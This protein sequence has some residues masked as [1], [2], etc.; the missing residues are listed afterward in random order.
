CF[1]CQLSAQ[2]P[3]LT[4]YL[5]DIKYDDDIPTPESYLGYQIG[6]W[7]LSHDQQLAYLRLLADRSPRVTLTEYA[8]TFERRPLIYLTITSEKNQ[9]RLPELQEAHLA[10][11]DPSKEAPD[12]TDIPA[13]VYQGFAIHGNEPS[14]GNAA[15]LVAY[16]LAAAKGREVERLLDEVIILLDPCL[17]PDG[18]HRFSTWANMHKNQRLTGDPVEREYNEVWPRGRTNHYWFDLNRDWLLVQMPESQG[19]I[20]AFQSWKPNVLTDHHEMGANAT[21]FF[22]PGV[23]ER[24]HPITP[25]RNQELTGKIAT[26]NQAAL[27]DIGSLYYSGEGFDDYYYGKGSTY[28]DGNGCIGILYE[29]ASSRGH[30]QKTENGDLTFPFTIRNQVVTALSTQKAAKELRPELLDYQREFYVTG[31]QE[32]QQDQRK[33][34]IFGDPHDAS[35]VDELVSILRQHQIEVYEL[36]EQY[37]DG[38]TVYAPGKAFVVPTEQK[39]Y[40]LVRAAFETL[41]TFEDSIFYDV[42][43]WTLPLAFNLDYTTIDAATLPRLQGDAV[44]G[45]RVLRKLQEPES[46][47]YAYLL[48]WDDYYAPKALYQIQQKGLRTKVATRNFLLNGK[49]YSY[50]TIMVPVQN[51][52]LNAEEIYSLMETV[53][54]TTGV[55]IDFADTGLTPTGIDL[56]SRDFDALKQPKTLLLVGQGVSPYEA[57]E[58]WHLLDARFDMEIVKVDMDRFNRIDLGK[59]NRIVMVDGSYGSLGDRGVKK[60]KTWVSEGGVL[61]ALKRAAQWANSK[62][63]ANLKVKKTTTN[64]KGRRPYAKIGADRGSEVIGGAIFNAQLDITHPIAYGYHKA[65]MPVFRRGTFFF[66][67]SKN[68]YA[69]PMV[70][71]DDPLISGYIKPK[72]LETLKGSATI[73]VNG[74]GSGRVICM[75]DNPNF[76]AFWYGTNKLFLNALFFGDIIS[77]SA[78]ERIGT[79]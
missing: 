21:F 35:R 59:Y 46:S 20:R 13:V 33:A 11:S 79:D 64:E 1:I 68:A 57:G 28:P 17:N 25:K 55:A 75:A 63:L 71:T 26:F 31:L 49:S 61:V 36:A 15:V 8:Q 37:R 45:L 69:T 74:M 19:R 3:A 40:R 4:Y 50:G 72:N 32:A 76:R 44:E 18:F 52:K 41:T 22:M 58:V 73:V 67:P 9:K 66:E 27:D 53:T 29:Q 47:E 7:H 10:A 23:P 24:T 42:S 62:G 65:Q 70:Y 39:Q 38:K 6:E 78:T 56:G 77:S 5:P 51:Q 12:F 14:A 34:Y 60:L 2:T 54:R 43:S 16:Y 48:P 30:Y